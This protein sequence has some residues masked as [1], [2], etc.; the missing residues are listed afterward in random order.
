[1]PL[2]LCG[3]PLPCTWSFQVLLSVLMLLEGVPYQV[4]FGGTGQSQLLSHVLLVPGRAGLPVVHGECLEERVPV[5]W[6]PRPPVSRC[7]P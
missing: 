4:G 5:L 2:C 6:V 3:L 7:P 1:M